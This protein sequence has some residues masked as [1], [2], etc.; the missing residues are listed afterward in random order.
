MV[1]WVE[2]VKTDIQNTVKPLEPGVVQEKKV[3][4]GVESAPKALTQSCAK[5]VL[6]GCDAQKL[7][8]LRNSTLSNVS[9]QDQD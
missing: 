5:T 1:L 3:A 9:V 7:I 6:Q 2:V 8:V 4:K